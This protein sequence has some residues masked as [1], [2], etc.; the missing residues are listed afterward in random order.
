VE[1]NINNDIYTMQRH[2]DHILI[3]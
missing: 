1:T 2:K 3:L